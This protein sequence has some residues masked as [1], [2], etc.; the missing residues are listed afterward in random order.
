LK[1]EFQLRKFGFGHDYPSLFVI[2]QCFSANLYI[3]WAVFWALFYTTHLALEVYYYP[4]LGAKYFIYVTNISYLMQSAFVF[5]DLFVTIYVNVKRKDIRNG[6]STGLTWYVKLQWLLFNV[7]NSFSLLASI[8]YYTL[9]KVEFTY[10]SIYTHLSSVY[11]ILG[12]LFSA[13]PVQLLHFYQPMIPAVVYVVF[14]IIYHNSGGERI[15][16]ILDW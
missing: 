9:L 1:E 12:L 4:D 8:V 16:P 13:K 5:T 14:S 6:D 11:T 15:Y 3:P 10:S 2:P 7:T